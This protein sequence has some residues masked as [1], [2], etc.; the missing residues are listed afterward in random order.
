MD[1]E[2]NIDPF[3]FWENLTDFLF[4]DPI[5]IAIDIFLNGGWVVFVIA[6][7]VG[8]YLFWLSGRRKKF[9]GKWKHVLLAIDI[10]KN[11]EQSPKAVENIFM[12]LAATQSGGNL[13]DNYWD[14]KV[15]ESFSFEVV[16]LEGYIQ[17]LVRTPSHFRDLIEAS[18]Y[19]QYPD[20]EITEVDDYAVRF[21]ELRF[22]SDT[23]GLWGSDMVLV[24]DYPYPIRT[25]N[26]F[27]NPIT[28][29]IVPGM[30]PVG[31]FLDPMA[32]LLEVMSRFGP[33]EQAWIQ[34]IVTPMP[35]GWDSK[36]ERV[37]KELMGEKYEAPESLSVK[38]IS[39]PLGV[40]SGIGDSVT[41]AIAPELTG[42]EASA[43][44]KKD[45]KMTM[46]QVDA[47]KGIQMK[48]AKHGMNLKFR[49]VYL[50]ENEVFDKGKGV[51][52]VIGAIQQFNTNNAN[53]FKPG[54]KSKTGA[55]YFRVKK[56]V[57]KKQN[58]ILEN[59]INRDSQSG[60]KA[61]NMMFNTEEL[62]SLWHFPVISVKA[63]AMERISSRKV[64][65]PTRLPF[66]ERNITGGGLS[67]D[68]GDSNLSVDDD[69]TPQ[70]P[71][72][73]PTG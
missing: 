73:L 6:L 4:R 68:S 67:T 13:I 71:A 45:A 63:P 72:N 11:N 66:E 25:Y 53:G 52:G 33:G 27:I 9:A 60:D 28:R 56:R 44:D 50:A 21:S 14:G 19:A 55:D 8:L 59:Y 38:A 57:A 58:E 39:K 5:T 32:A 65:P 54:S 15:Q 31:N 30:A 51:A 24:R 17:F 26:D 46:V 62:A 37:V 22:P 20:A 47:L 12:A 35:P 69:V 42:K 61:D 7:I 3:G 48:L 64:I 29:G 36:A 41:R 10:P 34:L 70:P 23:H 1:I 2:L 18:I 40:L 49:F 16:S 43:E